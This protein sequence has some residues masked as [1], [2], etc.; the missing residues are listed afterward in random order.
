MQKPYAILYMIN[1][2]RKFL[3]LLKYDARFYDDYLNLKIP[4]VLW[5]SMIYGLRH[6][7]FLAAYKLMPAEVLSTDW[8]AVQL[9]PALIFLDIPALMV[10]LSTGHRL[11]EAH[12]IMRLVWLNGRKLLLCSYLGSILLFTYLNF[13]LIQKF[14]F[15]NLS[16]I[17]SVLI[18]DIVISLYLYKSNL[19][20]D[21]FNEFPEEAKK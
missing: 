4:G 19:T 3:T 9:S 20:K 1:S 5:L 13:D 21:I 16:L 2:Y 12:K 14:T 10:L 8:L 7:I 6:I 18:F 15:E 11:P 17:F